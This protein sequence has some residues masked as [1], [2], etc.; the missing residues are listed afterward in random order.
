VDEQMVLA[1]TRHLGIRCY[2]RRLKEIQRD[3]CKF[4]GM[5]EVYESYTEKQRFAAYQQ[6][7]SESDSASTKPVVFLGHNS[8]DVFEN[9]IANVLKQQ[10]Y[11]DLKGMSEI[12]ERHDVAVVRPMLQISKLAIRAFAHAHNIPHLEDSTPAWTQRGR[13]RDLKPTLNAFDPRLI[14][15]MSILATR[16]S[17]SFES[18]QQH[19]TAIANNAVKLSH[20]KWSFEMDMHTF[21]TFTERQWSELVHRITQVRTTHKSVIHLKER[22]SA[23]LATPASHHRKQPSSSCNVKL[24]AKLSMHATLHSPSKVCIELRLS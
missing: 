17:E 18:M 7:H 9:I 1:W 24:S 8:D 13:T 10:K 6:A 23:L 20:N 14:P 2:V 11:E 22:T 4:N 15:A 12:I 3:P 19:I 5:R 21:Q 16:V